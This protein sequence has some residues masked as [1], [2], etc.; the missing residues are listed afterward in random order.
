LTLRVTLEIIPHGDEKKKYNIGYIDIHN[1]SENLNENGLN[2]YKGILYSD[3]GTVL[4]ETIDGSLE[5][6]RHEGAWSLALKAI[7]CLRFHKGQ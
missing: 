6:Y 3:G 4:K 7:E 2:N 5:H 1:I